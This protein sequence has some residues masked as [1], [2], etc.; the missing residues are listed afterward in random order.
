MD[1]EA[2]TTH[3][4]LDRVLDDFSIPRIEE[5]LPRDF[6]YGLGLKFPQQYAIAC[7]DVAACVRRAEELGA[8]PFLHATLAAPNWIEEGE[9][10]RDCRLEFALGYAG[11]TQIEFLGPG[12]GT[13]HYARALV[14][15]DVAF[16]H[17]G[18]YQKGM[19]RISDSL[20]DAGYRTVVR[21]GVSLDPAFKIDFRYFDARQE[22]GVYFEVLD[23][24]CLGF[25]LS[26]EPIIRG[27]AALKRAL[28]PFSKG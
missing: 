16:H 11:D 4:V 9:L 22:H 2:L 20:E 26:I 19:E 6:F 17:V 3:H 23:F 21:G 10:R 13:E 7:R 1:A 5:R 28:F 14:N 25:E 24:Q 8:G 27:H 15:T 18:I 12:E